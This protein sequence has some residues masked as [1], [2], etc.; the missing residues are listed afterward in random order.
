MRHTFFFNGKFYFRLRQLIAIPV[1]AQ[2]WCDCKEKSH[3]QRSS[4]T[5]GC[6]PPKVVSHW[7]SSSTKEVY[8]RRSSSTDSHLPPKVIFH[9]RS[10][11]FHCR[12]SSTKGHL[13]CKVVF[14]WRSS[15][16]EGRHSQK[17]I[18]HQSSS[19]RY[20]T[21]VDLIHL[22]DLINN[23]RWYLRAKFLSSKN[24]LEPK[25]VF[26]LN[27]LFDL[28]LPNKRFLPFE[29]N[30]LI[31]I[32]PE[33]MC[34]IKKCVQDWKIRFLAKK[35]HC[36]QISLLHQMIMRIYWKDIWLK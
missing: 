30:I 35:V 7:R 27:N 16:T 20:V 8:H 4:S 6:L 28:F 21:F 17:V 24:F 32:C 12:L 25:A 2:L 31:V 26:R 19:S 1:W 3:H 5:G 11:I 10:S 9:Q 14:H 34:F 18:F 15:S 36:Y 33:S 13:T 29:A 23:V 22:N